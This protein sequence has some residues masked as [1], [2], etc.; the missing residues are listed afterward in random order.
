MKTKLSDI[1][2]RVL[3]VDDEESIGDILYRFLTRKG[4]ETFYTDDSSEVIPLVKR[5][6]PHLVLLDINLDGADG[7][8]LLQEIKE[9]DPKVAVIMITA[10]QEDN[11]GK[12]ALKLGAV[13]FINKPIDLEYLE[14][15]LKIKISALLD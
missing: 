14:T 15:S 5:A 3:V 2:I 9:L 13:D 4:Y 10:M 7:I 1:P 8:D 12:E 6:R 11:L